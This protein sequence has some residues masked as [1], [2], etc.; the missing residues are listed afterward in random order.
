[1]KSIFTISLFLL[2]SF[3]G[4]AQSDFYTQRWGEVYKFEIKALPKSALSVVDTIYRK[5]KKD[6][7]IPQ[8]T[9][10]LIYKSKFA[11]T[12]SESA[13]LFVIDQF[14]TEIQQSK[15]PQRNILESMLA[16]LY[17][18]YFQENRWKFYGRSRTSEKVNR[19]DFRTWDA[20][21]VF[22]EIAGHYT[23]SLHH[24]ETLQK[25]NLD[26][27]NEVLIQAENSKRYRPTLYDFIAHNAIEFYKTN[28]STIYKSA[29]PFKV[30]PIYFEEFKKVQ[31]ESSDSLQPTL[32]AFTLLQS[33][34]E[35]HYAR[36][37]TI[38]YLNLE[39]ERLQLLAE[40]SKIVIESSVHQKALRTLKEKY[41]RHSA[42]TQIDFELASLI[43]Q[44]TEED[45]ETKERKY[46]K[47]DALGVCNSAIAAFP[48]SDGAAKCEIL[49]AQI[50]RKSLEI[51]CEE[52]LPSDKPSY[53][54]VRY[55]NIQHLQFSIYKV[56]S[57]FE[58]DF[59]A[60]LNDSTRLLAINKL[61]PIATWQ[62][63]LKNLEDYET[64]S[65]EV[66][67]PSVPHGSYLIVAQTETDTRWQ[68]IFG[69]SFTQ[70]TNLAII[71]GTFKKDFRYQIVNRNTGAPISEAN[72][73]MQLTQWNN[74]KE[75]SKS[76][77]LTTDKNGFCTLE[78]TDRNSWNI[79]ATVS[80]EQDTA[81]FGNFYV[82]Q[83]YNSDP[84]DDKGFSAKSFLFTDRSIYRP[85]QT[86]YFKG[87]LIKTKKKK[88][89]T[90][91]GE[92]VETFLE[93]VN[94][95]EVSTARLKTNSYG[96]FSGEFK[97]PLNGLTGEYT[98]YADE[99]DEDDS[100]FY[101]KLD[102]FDAQRLDISVEEY[103]R[104]TF[105][106]TLKP[107]EK[108]FKVNDTI[109]IKGVALAYNGSKISNGKVSYH[110]QRTVRYPSWYYWYNPSRY[111]SEQE[112]ESDETT[113]N[114]DGEFIVKFPA[115]PDD[116]ILPE[117]LPIFHY[118]ITADVTDVN[119]ETRS[120][121]TATKVGYHTMT[122]TINSSTIIEKK[123]A[124]QVTTIAT[125]N[126]NGVFVPAK[127]IIKI[128]KLKT[129]SSPV[130]QRPWEQPD[131][132]LLSEEEFKNTFP[133][134]AYSNE[135]NPAKWEKG[136]LM[137][138]LEFDTEQSKEVKW[139]IDQKWELGSYL[140]ELASADPYGMAV[141]D[142]FKF[143]VI[144]KT[145]KRLVDNQLFFF[146]T[147]KSNYQVGEVVKV[148]FGS[149]STNITMMVDVE[150][151]NE[152]VKTYIEKL[153]NEIKELNIPVTELMAD[154]FAIHCTAVN[155][156]SFL[157]ERK[158][159]SVTEA[160][161]QLEIEVVSFKD[162]LQ[163]GAKETW[164]FE[165][166]GDEAL[167]REAEILASMYDASLD[168][169]KLHEWRFEP[170]QKNPYYGY[171]RFNGSYSF[172]I[173]NFTI[174]N[175]SY[176][177]SQLPKQYYDQLDWFG[178]SLTNN[179]YVRQRYLERLYST[180]ID[181]NNP[182]KVS[183][184]NVKDK[185]AGYIYGK[186]T[187]SDGTA[188]PGVNIVIKGTTQGT[189]TDAN[190]EYMIEA[191]K[192]DNLVF[193]FIGYSTA[194]AKVGRK[195][196]IN[197]M[198]EEDVKAL[199]EVVVTGYG[200]VKEKKSLGYAITNATSVSDSTEGLYI[201]FESALQGKVAGVQITGT[202]GGS[203]RIMLR[204]A[205]S[206]DASSNPL[207]V[208][209][210]IV[211]ESSKIDQSDLAEIQVLKGDAALAI[212]GSRGANGV[213]IITTK[214]GQKKLD[215]E[216]AKIT[217][218]KKFNETAFFFPHIT[219]D[220]TG[221]LQFTF[222]TPES[223]TRWKLQLL[224]HTRELATATKTLQAVTQKELMVT[225][226]APRFLR[227]GDEIFF[228]VKI[229]NLTNQ[230]KEGKIGLQLSDVITNNSI[231]AAFN[232]ITKN[233][234]FT[235][236]A[237]GNT[238]VSWKLQIP[239]GVDAVLYRVV[240][241]S[242]SQSDGE[243]NILPILSNRTLVT[244][245]MAMH[246]QEGQTKT[247]ALQKLKN[248]SSSSLQHHQLTL[249]VTSNP[250]WYAIQSL[251]YLMEFPHECAEQTFSRYYAN[252]LA[253]YVATSNPK[254]KAV[255]DQ[256]ASG[257]GLISN[258][259]K[260]PELKSILIQ[261][262]PWLRDAQSE[263]EQK[264]RMALFFDSNNLKGQAL[265]ATDKL[266]E[267]Q[268]ANGGFPWF[269]GSD[270]TNRFITQHVATGFGHLKHLKVVDEKTAL[271]EIV[272][273]AIGYLDNELISDYHLMLEQASRIKSNAKNETEGNTKSK[274]YIPEKHIDYH[275]IQYLYMRSFF[276]ENPISENLKMAVDYYRKQS[277]TY[278]QDFNLYSK[279]MIALVHHRN[280]NSK[281]A[282]EIAQSLYENSILNKE[283]GRYWKENQ[284]GWYW[285]QAPIETHA[286]LIEL[287]SEIK[288][289]T[290]KNKIVD[291]LRIWLLKN[292]QT[293]QWKTTKATTEAIYALLLNGTDWISL[294]KQVQV[295]VGDK[296]IVPNI[297][298]P[299]AGTGYFKKQWKSNEV[300]NSLS[301]VVIAKKDAGIAWAGLYWQYF[302]DLDKITSSETALKLTKKVFL[303]KRDE[304]GE[305]LSE[306]K[307]TNPLAVGNLLRVRI[308]L[309]VDRPME[310]LHMK[311]MR[312]SGLEPVDV[313]SEYKWQEDLGY[314]QS[315]KDA[316]TH[317]FFDYMTPGIYVF[318]YDLRVGS[319]GN[320]SNG[321][322]TIQNMYAPEFSSHSEG[323]R[324]SVN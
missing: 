67:V 94:G 261:E 106:V 222:T 282:N 175:L 95:Q 34:L 165:I 295:S 289:T 169:F 51:T 273:K 42:S 74:N 204:G 241:K 109:S 167:K 268:F 243:Q 171:E 253:S 231:D 30:K 139:S 155:F 136:K 284:S 183:M 161:K 188:L 28:E 9:K 110:V 144:E 92:Y 57:S 312:A 116:K 216:L 194:E 3:L 156:N 19:Q 126:L 121:T 75:I 240:A 236:S 71:D 217:V 39:L 315:T 172:G 20:E 248:N 163:P 16:N 10:T 122:A 223:L 227:V 79:T 99:D 1:M 174:G 73:L 210:G 263:T 234:T 237:K 112:I 209:D 148:K 114:A 311:D 195:N 102:N 182:S 5:A 228:S 281:L 224:A 36:K 264:K 218:R 193:S 48:K 250:A 32:K 26:N 91:A 82:Y 187:T 242:G 221:K 120:G 232:N 249:E 277:A 135:H 13:E 211:V 158:I 307:E 70:V 47:R 308:E 259:E 17:W 246:V 238:E 76:V 63:H 266:K 212:Y 27:L 22:K 207:Y 2:Q 152:I 233:K 252:T 49:K 137:L 260:N 56:G 72:V 78:I 305:I 124:N 129:P 142:K 290:D 90:V 294:D 168:Q 316:A 88:S 149:A 196:T 190:G 86:V 113:T 24:P 123:P 105:E 283:L 317:F 179:Y 258:L 96:S 164:S 213:I 244:E 293:S 186:I 118:A 147:D 321:I 198:M 285:Y 185:K 271:A 245:T 157:T 55:A 69:Y 46:Y 197:V 272:A 119:G 291:D 80:Y 77:N 206:M 7:N 140:I 101:D 50:T 229:S 205:S 41:K 4:Q 180:G 18:Q 153:S 145:N 40:Q 87:I 309:A 97:L 64:H 38:A 14:K 53:L 108:A 166:K 247:F 203:G 265:A 103:K 230:N 162:K 115:I 35:F 208:V 184:L 130:R 25:Y 318:E 138:S 322:T 306:V 319:K 176:I 52:F 201:K 304:K 83:G 33:L 301:K 59:R 65:T 278:W 191:D 43:L 320:F 287:F 111:S 85:G 151:G 61:K 6:N 141:T 239:T 68:P 189:V 286:L 11:F 275:Q 235:I 45:S 314:Y 154:G 251:P 146:E 303:V 143:K 313:L 270:Y 257:D 29:S 23:Q 226:N 31:I 134:D 276:P 117:A 292:K 173:Q 298:K 159:I 279:G 150:R 300:N 202:P 267:M 58:H 297:N 127:G 125:E 170:I 220:E 181:P 8:F 215:E 107:A 100:K 60:R 323:V 219:T 54:L 199:S 81:Q 104:P 132:P 133:H 44:E 178:F 262:T 12:L 288:I 269:K 93:D 214:S 84:D 296:D 255:F 254:I 177:N 256:W 280:N 274:E 302:E 62:S 200:T 131:L 89:T 310:F 21:A 324:I 37:D 192:N 225:P 15:S 299:E 98:L 160:K 128:F 66:V